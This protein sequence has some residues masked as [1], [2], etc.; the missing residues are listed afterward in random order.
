[1]TCPYCGRAALVR[2]GHSA[3]GKHR[4]KCRSCNRQSRD[5]PQPNGYPAERREEILR[6]YQARASVRGIERTFT[7][8][9]NTVSSWLL[10]KGANSDL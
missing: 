2:N 1:M 7:V 3:N 10:K 4:Y 5:N 9:R 8:A 6:A